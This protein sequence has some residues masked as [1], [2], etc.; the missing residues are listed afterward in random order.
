VFVR[1]GT[2]WSQQAYLKASNTGATDGFGQWVSASGDTVVVGAYLE[3][4]NA[5]G[6]DGNQ[7]DNSA[8]QSG[9]AYVFVR[10]GTTWSQQAYLKASN[11]GASDEFGW[12]VSVSG[13]TVVVGAWGEDSNATGVGG[14]QSDNSAAQSGAA[15][16][17]VRN[18]TTWSQQ[19]YFKASNTDPD[20]RFGFSTSASD[21]TVVVG[22]RN[23]ASNATKVNGNQADNNANDA[24]AAYVFARN[25]T[26]WKQQA[27]LKPSNTGAA[28]RFGWSVSVSGDTLV[29]GG[30]G[31]SSNATGV[32]GNQS[33][34][35]AFDSGA[36]YVFVRNDKTWTQQAYL[37]ASNVDGLDQFGHSVSASGDTVVVG[38]WGEDSNATGVDGNQS[39]N[40]AALSG[41]AY[42]FTV[43][44]GA[45]TPYGTGCAGTGGF[46][47]SLSM[48]GCAT[49]NG[50]ITLQIAS[51]LG[52]AP[53][54]LL[55]GNAQASLPLGGG[56]TLLVPPL[57]SLGLVLSGSGAGN[58]AVSLPATLDATTPAVTAT[59]QAAIFDAGNPFGFSMTNGVQVDVQ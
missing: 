44:C 56:C 46:I 49:G 43:P 57:F 36:A 22:A 2:T 35:S 21:D 52:G 13:D 14:N 37:K 5:A 26:T 34:N 30:F 45:I 7:S 47:P 54:L 32:N 17:F 53:V 1:N 24:G 12:S 38:A 16:V 18:G 48:T 51:G 19:A 59:V 40:S 15:Y 41:A 42:V 9:A 31:E 27:Y 50:T 39:D 58:G 25:G 20:D 8:A 28:D 3:D 10:N 11:T 33:D 55:I 6:V 4:S 23:E 29:A